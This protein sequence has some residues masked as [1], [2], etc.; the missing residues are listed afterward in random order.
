MTDAILAK[1]PG[2][3]LDR[4]V[5]SFAHGPLHHLTTAT[6]L[7]SSCPAMRKEPL[8]A[9]CSWRA[10]HFH[11]CPARSAEQCR[12]CREGIASPGPHDLMQIQAQTAKLFCRMQNPPAKSLTVQKPC[13]DRALPAFRRAHKKKKRQI[14]RFNAFYLV[15]S[16]ELESRAL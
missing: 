8:A 9:R 10:R 6:H 2:H 5:F 1:M 15:R 4:F 12:P 13:T 16:R 14:L 7:R 11:V 3:K